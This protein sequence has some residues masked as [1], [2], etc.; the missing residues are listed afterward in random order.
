VILRTEWKPQD[1]FYRAVIAEIIKPHQNQS[2][3]PFTLGDEYGNERYP[4]R[5]GTD[6]GDGE[7]QF[8]TGSP[9]EWQYSS[10]TRGAKLSGLADAPLD[11]IRMLAREEH[12]H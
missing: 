7:I 4:I 8:F 10:V 6:Y 9:P 12:A 3:L 2:A 11:R 1:G 5:E